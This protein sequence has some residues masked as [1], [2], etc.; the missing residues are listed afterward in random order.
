M[1]FIAL[2]FLIVFPASTLYGKPENL[3]IRVHGQF[4]AMA[5]GCSTPYFV[6]AL[7]RHIT[8]PSDAGY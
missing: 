8:E 3:S 7:W 4:M 6:Q 2:G 5:C 1:Q